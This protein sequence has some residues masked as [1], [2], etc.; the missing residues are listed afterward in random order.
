MTI[1]KQLQIMEEALE[2]IRNNTDCSHC[3]S[4]RF[5][6]DTIRAM[7]LKLQGDEDGKANQF[8][9]GKAVVGGPPVE[10]G[11]KAVIFGDAIVVEDI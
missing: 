10:C 3:E 9:S 8:S 7:R 5:I 4:C 1:N 2:D 6:R 11:G